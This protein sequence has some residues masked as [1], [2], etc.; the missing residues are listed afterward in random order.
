MLILNT[1]LIRIIKCKWNDVIRLGNDITSQQA[2]AHYCSIDSD[3]KSSSSIPQQEDVHATVLGY[4][5]PVIKQHYVL[6]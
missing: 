2:D 5:T 6:A 4:N 3:T 1:L